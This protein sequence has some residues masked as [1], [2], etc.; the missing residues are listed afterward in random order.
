MEHFAK[1]VQNAVCICIPPSLHPG[2]LAETV[3]LKQGVILNSEFH[4]FDRDG[5]STESS[6]LK[7]FLPVKLIHRFTSPFQL[8]QLQYSMVLQLAAAE[9]KKKGP[10]ASELLAMPI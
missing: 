8:R 2:M 1:L 10:Q 3:K 7:V 6:L 4:Y 5:I 9:R